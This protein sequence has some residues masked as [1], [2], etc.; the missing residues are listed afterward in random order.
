MGMCV[1]LV[2]TSEMLRE[3]AEFFMLGMVGTTFVDSAT[4]D[5]F[6]RSRYFLDYSKASSL[7]AKERWV[8]FLGTD[9]AA[10]RAAGSTS[11]LF[12]Y[13]SCNILFLP[14]PVSM[15]KDDGSVW[16]P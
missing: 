14:L 1:A 8:L 2:W 10:C 13:I 12:L 11:G 4:R 9:W 16:S 5:D 3:I 15:V 7:G 6:C